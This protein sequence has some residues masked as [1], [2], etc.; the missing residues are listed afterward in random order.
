MERWEE[1]VLKAHLMWRTDFG[2]DR[3]DRERLVDQGYDGTVE[4]SVNPT[5]D[6]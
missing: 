6:I 4:R 5:D 3:D 1:I 2:A